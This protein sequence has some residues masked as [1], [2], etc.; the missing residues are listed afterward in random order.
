MQKEQPKEH[1]IEFEIRSDPTLFP[2]RSV[3]YLSDGIRVVVSLPSQ[4]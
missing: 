1:F 3:E 2:P 4:K